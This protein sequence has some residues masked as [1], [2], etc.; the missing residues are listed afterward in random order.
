MR[1]GVPW[2]KDTIQAKWKDSENKNCIYG[3]GMEQCPDFTS[4]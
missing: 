2:L 4:W 3:K 1:S